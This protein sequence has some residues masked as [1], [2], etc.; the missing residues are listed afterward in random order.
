[1]E[2]VAIFP[3]MNGPTGGYTDIITQWYA[4]KNLY[5]TAA[6]GGINFILRVYCDSCDKNLL[7]IHRWARSSSITGLMILVKPGQ[8]VDTFN[9]PQELQLLWKGLKKSCTRSMKVRSSTLMCLSYI[10]P[11][12]LSSRAT[13]VSY[14]NAAESIRNPFWTLVLLPAASICG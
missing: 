5:H 11:Q 14:F 8:L 2:G 9:L 13:A 12:L 7:I 4:R 1:M 6:V 10:S 3:Q